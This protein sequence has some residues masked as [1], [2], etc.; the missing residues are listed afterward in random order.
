M[1][2]NPKQEKSM[3]IKPSLKALRLSWQ[4]SPSVW[5]KSPATLANI[6]DARI[7]PVLDNPLATLPRTT[8]SLYGGNS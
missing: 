6:K 4:L 3:K 7:C 8:I 1:E 2:I 5:V